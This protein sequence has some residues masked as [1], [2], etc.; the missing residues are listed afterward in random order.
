MDSLTLR[1]ERTPN[2]LRIAAW[3]IGLALLTL[4]MGAVITELLHEAGILI[5]SLFMSI[6]AGA[7]GWQMALRRAYTLDGRGSLVRFTD[8]GV[9]VPLD[10]GEVLHFSPVGLR[11]FTGFLD[12]T[13]ASGGQGATTRRMF[14]LQLVNG[15]QDCWLFAEQELPRQYQRMEQ[16]RVIPG[17]GHEVRVWAKDL[18]QA[19]DALKLIEPR[20]L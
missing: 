18:E 14:W 19:I 9:E 3:S 4:A 13:D 1:P 10:S 17:H 5:A 15:G 16:H 12:E 2:T 8:E 20:E 7:A 6:A 11:V